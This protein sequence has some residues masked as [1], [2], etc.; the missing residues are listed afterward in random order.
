MA[1]LVQDADLIVSIVVPSAAKR[2]AAKVAKAIGK[3]GRRDLLYLDANA[4]SPMTADEIGKL[5]QSNGVNFIDGC[6]IGSAT[7]MDKGAVIYASGPQA[8]KIQDLE[9]YGFSVKVLGPTVA[10]A[11]AFKVV[12]AGLTKGLQGLFVELLMG[13]R[14][15]GLLDEISK[16]Y[17]ESFPGLLDKVTSSIVGLRIHAGRRAEEMDELKRTFAY[18]GMKAVMAPAVQKV[19]QS[20]AALDLG[21]ETAGRDGDLMETVELFFRKG[22]LQQ[23]Q[24]ESSSAEQVHAAG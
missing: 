5:L 10:Q 1:T 11:S 8:A 9:P 17:E 16:R 3:S 20:I 24:T 6:I 13:A 2:V 14:R 22:L 23:E 4:I 7:K 19:L 15:F 18:H 21:K 12:Y